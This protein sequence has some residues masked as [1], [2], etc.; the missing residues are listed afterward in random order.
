MIFSPDSKSGDQVQLVSF[1]DRDTTAFCSLNKKV[2][3]SAP[4]A[5]PATSHTAVANVR[6]ASIKVNLPRPYQSDVKAA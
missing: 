2:A 1:P 3:M 4:K 6:N 5:Q